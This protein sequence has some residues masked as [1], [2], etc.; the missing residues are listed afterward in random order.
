[1]N[2][3][4]RIEPALRAALVFL[5]LAVGGA[6]NAQTDDGVG[7]EASWRLDETPAA[8]GGGIEAPTPETDPAELNLEKTE[9]P[10]PLPSEESDGLPDPAD[11]VAG[12]ALPETQIAGPPAPMIRQEGAEVLVEAATDQRTAVIVQTRLKGQLRYEDLGRLEPGSRLRLTGLSFERDRWFRLQE[13]EGGLGA[14]FGP[15]RR[16]VPDWPPPAVTIEFVEDP[17]ASFLVLH[18]GELP[19]GAVGLALVEPLPLTVKKQLQLAPSGESRLELP[20]GCERVRISTALRAGGRLGGWAL[21]GEREVPRAP[22]PYLQD[23]L[24]I[25]EAIRP[26][27]DERLESNLQVEAVPGRLA[28][29][30]TWQPGL[31][32][33]GGQLERRPAGTRSFRPLAETGETPG[34]LDPDL[35]AGESYEYRL[36]W[37]EPGHRRISD[38]VS[39]AIGIPRLERLDVIEID[40]HSARLSWNP[41]PDI[42][43]FEIEELRNL[44]DPVEGIYLDDETEFR[45]IASPANTDSTLLVTDLS[46]EQLVRWRIVCVVDGVRGLPTHS[47]DLQTVFPQPVFTY[48]NPDYPG[49]RVDLHFALEPNR[50]ESVDGVRLEYKDA[51]DWRLAGELHDLREKVFVDTLD[52]DGQGRVYRMVAWNDHNLRRSTERLV[53]ARTRFDAPRIEGVRV[54]DLASVELSWRPPT[55]RAVIS[56]TLVERR[57]ALEEEFVAVAT[58][59][60]ADS[61][62]A[63]TTL[64]AELDV[65]YRLRSLSGSRQSLPSR[66]LRARVADPARGMLRYAEGVGWRGDGGPEALPDEGPAR[67]VRV[68]AFELGEAEVSNKEYLTFCESTGR[69]LP[70]DPAFVGGSNAIERWPNAAVVNVSWWD[71][72]DYCNWLSA[73]SGLEPAYDGTGRPVPGSDGYRL[74]TEAEFEYAARG[75][76]SAANRVAELFDIAAVNLYGPDDT[77][78]GIDFLGSKDWARTP[79]GAVHLMGNVWEWVQDWYHPEYYR[80]SDRRIDPRGPNEGLEKVRKGGGFD[81]VPEACRA[82]YRLATR[83]DL[84]LADTGFRVARSLRAIESVEHES[85]PTEDFGILDGRPKRVAGESAFR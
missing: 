77:A 55:D 47:A 38:I 49:G 83:P 65:W 40:D 75:Q 66:P 7:A 60:P 24:T 53:S 28:L 18:C 6:L 42:Q 46:C 32:G 50:P 5:L 9:V 81:L 31:P 72:V 15:E 78:V 80:F 70:P 34:Y 84:R 61:C 36:T 26:T 59:G 27:V 85:P 30:L 16:F 62:W 67:R 52:E 37:M 44:Y 64:L 21:Q 3:I 8:D 43:R 1:M 33:P 29:R 54:I 22:E 76:E 12:P 63:D 17:G 58:T 48:E 13:A 41:R 57:T 4:G 45:P 71:A 20:A 74:P 79:E 14:R 73:I 51:V 11:A 2:R 19:E 35:V 25:R 56:G 69:A 39:G 68:L 82:S 23:L 10:T